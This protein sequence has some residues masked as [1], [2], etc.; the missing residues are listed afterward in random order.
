[1]TEVETQEWWHFFAKSEPSKYVLGSKRQAEDYLKSLNRH[2]L[3][4]YNYVFEPLCDPL[5]LQ[6]LNAFPGR[7]ALTRTYEVVTECV[8]LTEEGY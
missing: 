1:M 6:L 5:T 4:P 7:H 8:N 3:S 2:L